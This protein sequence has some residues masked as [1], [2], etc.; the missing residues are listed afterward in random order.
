MAAKPNTSGLVNCVLKSDGTEVPSSIEIVSVATYKD[1]NRIPYAT[2]SIVDGNVA[3]QSFDGI[4]NDLLKPGCELEI[5]AGVDSE[6]ATIFKGIIT[7]VGLKVTSKTSLLT[8]NCKD[9]SVKATGD[10]KTKIFTEVKDSDIYSTIATDA[11]LSVDSDTT[12]FQHEQVVQ[13]NATDWDF[14]LLRAEANGQVVI[15]DDGSLSIKKPSFSGSE[16]LTLEFG[17]NIISFETSLNAE[18]QVAEVEVKSWDTGSMDA[19]SSSGSSDAMDVGE[20]SN[21]DLADIVSKKYSVNHGGLVSE[22]ELK[23]WGDSIDLYRKMTKIQGVFTCFGT[24]DVSP[25]DIV[26][27]KGASN[28]FSG[29]HYVTGV[30]QEII[31]GGWKTKIQ[32][33]FPSEMF[34]EKFRFQPQGASGLMPAMNGLICGKV[35]KI[36]D[37]PNGEYRI[38]VQVPVLGDDVS[39]WARYT[40]PD[41]GSSRGLVYYPEVDDEVVLGFLNNDSRYPIILGSLFS[42]T[43]APPTEPEDTNA[44]KGFY[45]KKELKLLFND[46]DE[47]I[48]IETAG[49]NTIIVDNKGSSVDIKDAGGNEVKL[50]SSGIDISSASNLNIK[51]TGNIDINASGNLTLGGVNV[52]AAAQAS[53]KASGNAGANL[54]TSAIAVVKGSLVQIN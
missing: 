48:T 41:G 22:D 52:E 21:S 24:A 11:G 13:Y 14:I 25:G 26:E 33:G 17:T 44:E 3:D 28:R 16:S 42:G 35:S 47:T 10:K 27:I 18:K 6:S 36:A 4:E 43:N 1:I 12:T 2:I 51:A 15:A 7:Q 46:E 45:S 5:K 9:K 34:H 53:F 23:A 39:L 30:S 8:V 38:Q 49:G 20:I 32:I 29:K 50:S 37:D 31:G 19:L 54:E 40:V